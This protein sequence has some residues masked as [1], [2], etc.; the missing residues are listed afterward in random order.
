MCGWG[1]LLSGFMSTYA[2]SSDCVR[3][4]GDE[5]ERFRIGSGVREGCIMSPWLFNVYID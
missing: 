5:N 3:V 2:D 4:K 1:K